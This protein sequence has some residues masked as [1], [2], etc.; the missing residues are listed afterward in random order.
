MSPGDEPGGSRRGV[1]S[2]AERDQL[3]QLGTSMEFPRAEEIVRQGSRGDTMY[4]IERGAVD[5]YFEAGRGAKRLSA[6]ISHNRGRPKGGTGGWP[7]W[8]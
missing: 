6:S 2:E 7:P 3:V 5:F 8:R 1:L 4:I